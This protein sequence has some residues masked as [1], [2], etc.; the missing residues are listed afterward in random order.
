LATSGIENRAEQVR[1]ATTGRE[2]L[3]SAGHRQDLTGF[4]YGRDGTRKLSSVSTSLDAVA[5]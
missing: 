5:S 4:A 3:G 2:I 1:D